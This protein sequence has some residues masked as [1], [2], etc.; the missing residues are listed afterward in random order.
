LLRLGGLLGIGSHPLTWRGEVRK[1]AALGNSE[2][3][4]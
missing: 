1:I 2:R 4:V 3:A